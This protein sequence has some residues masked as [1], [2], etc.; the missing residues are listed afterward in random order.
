MPE[1]EKSWGDELS[2]PEKAKEMFQEMLKKIRGDIEN[3]EKDDK[4][5]PG[6]KKMAMD[7]LRGEEE[8]AEDCLKMCENGNLF[9]FLGTRKQ[10]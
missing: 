9:G 6:L 2:S 8:I 5:D 10:A 3:L 1:E 7:Q 4:V